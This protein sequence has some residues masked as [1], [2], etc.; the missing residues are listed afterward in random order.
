MNARSEAPGC[1]QAE[2][3]CLQIGIQQHYLSALLDSALRSREYGDR[4]F[5]CYVGQ[6]EMHGKEVAE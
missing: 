5:W 1:S 2:T 4:G 6:P 3:K